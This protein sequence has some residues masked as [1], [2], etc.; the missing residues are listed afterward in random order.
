MLMCLFSI[1]G[2]KGPGCQVRTEVI[3]I[4]IGIVA[5]D[6]N[7]NLLGARAVT[8]MV[9]AVPKVV[10]GMAALEAMLFS[11][12]SSFFRFDFLRPQIVCHFVEGIKTEL[13]A[14]RYASM[15]HMGREADNVAHSLAK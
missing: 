7:C 14:F 6:N 3:L 13:Q 12:E 11:K 10:E 9:V 8:K 4:G 15:V 1:R 2:H 5:R